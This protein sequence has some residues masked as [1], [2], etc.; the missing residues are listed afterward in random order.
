MLQL[1]SQ[2]QSLKLEKSALSDK[3]AELMALNENLRKEQQATQ[4]ARDE[5]SHKFTEV[6]RKYKH[7][8]S[9]KLLII[10]VEQF[11]LNLLFPSHRT[12]LAAKKQWPSF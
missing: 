5:I 9:E 6:D 7:I 4:Q 10:Q 11:S 3:V 8:L 1:Q 2:L 12:N